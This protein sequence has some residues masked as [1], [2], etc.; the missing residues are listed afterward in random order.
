[1]NVRT[2]VTSFGKYLQVCWSIPNTDL[3]IKMQQMQR[4]AGIGAAWP[5]T[6]LVA[7]IENPT[8]AKSDIVIFPRLKKSFCFSSRLSCM[9][10]PA[11]LQESFMVWM[12]KDLKLLQIMRLRDDKCAVYVC[13]LRRGG[14][15]LLPSPPPLPSATKMCLVTSRATQVHC[16][17][18]S[19][20]RRLSDST[21]YEAFVCSSNTLCRLLDDFMA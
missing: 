3:S 20:K 17:G 1:M 2:R 9:M 13:R 11:F 8:N 5:A 12:L 18:Y 6:L 19:F 15:G 10:M 21:P 16:Y 7:G 4:Q 14:G